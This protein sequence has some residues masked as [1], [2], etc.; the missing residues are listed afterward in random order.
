MFVIFNGKVGDAWVEAKMF[1]R[2]FLKDLPNF[3]EGGK[4]CRSEKKA[5]WKCLQALKEHDELR[6]KAKINIFDEMEI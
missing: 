5:S 4:S 2:L 3:S 6:R 1:W